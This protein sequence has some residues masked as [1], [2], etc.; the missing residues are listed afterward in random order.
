M[1]RMGRIEQWQGAAALKAIGA[2][3][4]IV[5]CRDVLPGP[6]CT[7]LYVFVHLAPSYIVK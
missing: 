3:S 6:G 2:S 5:E 4:A 1:L 7:L